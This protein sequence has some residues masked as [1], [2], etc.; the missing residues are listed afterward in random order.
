MSAEGP[1]RK[2]EQNRLGLTAER[3]LARLKTCQAHS[4]LRK[5]GTLLPS[6]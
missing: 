1:Q 6:A 5:T 2:S 4:P 3:K